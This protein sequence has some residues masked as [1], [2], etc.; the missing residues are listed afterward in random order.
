MLRDH[1]RA[2]YQELGDA[3]GLSAPGP[4]R[5]SALRARARRRSGARTRTQAAPGAGRAGARGRCRGGDAGSLGSNRS[6]ASGRR[7]AAGGSACRRRRARA[8]LV[9]QGAPEIAWAGARSR[10]WGRTRQTPRAGG[11][12]SCAGV[13]GPAAHAFLGDAR[14]GV[15]EGWRCTLGGQRRSQHHGD[16]RRWADRRDADLATRQRDGRGCAGRLS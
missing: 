7:A 13:D 11:R 3:I 8:H 5:A 10:S 4:P 12:T 9:A 14:S 16:R 2:T 6:A 15:R 1:A